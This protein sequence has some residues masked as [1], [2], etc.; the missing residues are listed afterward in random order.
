MF[1]FTVQSLITAT[2]DQSPFDLD[3]PA[4]KFHAT[5][6][7]CTVLSMK[8]D[9]SLQ[10]KPISSLIATAQIRHLY[11]RDVKDTKSVIRPPVPHHHLLYVLDHLHVFVLFRQH[12]LRNSA[13]LVKSVKFV[14]RRLMLFLPLQSK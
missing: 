12:A 1:M 2:S 11:S 4:S 8:V 3:L 7:Q 10:Y 9:Q 14:K 5:K 6:V 13:H